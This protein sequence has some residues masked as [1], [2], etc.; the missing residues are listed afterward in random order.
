MKIAKIEEAVGIA[1]KLMY[2][3]RVGKPFSFSTTPSK[4]LRK[5][6]MG[7]SWSVWDGYLKGL[8]H[9]HLPKGPPFSGLAVDT[10]LVDETYRKDLRS[11][12]HQLTKRIAL[13]DKYGV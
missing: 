2:A 12:R 13:K 5:G 4:P 8:V 3:E 7:V 6:G 10:P 11:L 1:I 9:D